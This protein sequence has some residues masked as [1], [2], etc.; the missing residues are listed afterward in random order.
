MASVHQVSAE[1]MPQPFV[2]EVAQ[3]LGRGLKWPR[4][5]YPGL[6]P[7][8]VIEGADE[9]LIFYGREEQ[10]DEILARLNRAHVVFVIGPSGCGKSSLIMAGVIPAL[11]AG[12]L[13]RAGHRWRCARMRPGR[14]P[15]ACLAEVLA[16]LLPDTHGS[17]DERRAAIE[18]LAR[19][20]DSALWL[21]A[22]T[23]A[24]R[25]GRVLLILDQFEELFAPEIESG[26]EVTQL[27]N[28]LTRFFE[29]PHENLYLVLAMRTD[30]MGR[31]AS[32]PHLAEMLNR[33]QYLTPVLTPA[34][35]RVAITRPAEA[36]GGRVEPALV[37][38]LLADMA[39]LHEDHAD[40]LPLLQ[41]ALFWLWEQAWRRSG[42]SEPPR[43]GQGPTS[44]M[45]ELA[46]EDYRSQ[47]RL[48]GILNAHA[49]AV[50][51]KAT[52]DGQ[53]GRRRSLC[54]CVFKRL[55]ERDL[56]YRYRR[57]PATLKEIADATDAKP[58]A[59][60]AVVRPFVAPN[61]SLLELRKPRR[62]GEDFVD[63]SHESL[64]RQWERLRRWADAEADDVHYFR[65]L[66]GSA[67]RWAKAGR[68][69]KDL[70][71]G[72]ELE[73]VQ[74][75]W[76]QRKP[77]QSWARR[78]YLDHRCVTNLAT[79][80]PLVEEYRRACEAQDEKIKQERERARRRE[81]E[82]LKRE[83]K[84]S[85]R[86]MWVSWAAG[87]LCTAVVAAAWW[88]NA[89]RAREEKAR[90]AAALGQFVLP[91]DG[92]NT[93]L[94]IAL[95]ALG[96]D[97]LPV[98][99]ETQQ[100]VR[101]ALADHRLERVILGH[102]GQVTSVDYRPDDG[103]LL[104]ADSAGTLRVWD[105]AENA[106][107]AQTKLSDLSFFCCRWSPLGDKV[108][109]STRE[110]SRAS[111]FEFNRDAPDRLRKLFDLKG[112]A[113]PGV[114]SHDERYIVTGSFLSPV[115][116]WDATNG[117][118]IRQIGGPAP[119]IAID[120]SSPRVAVATRDGVILLYDLDDVRAGVFEPRLK[121]DAAVP[122]GNFFSLAFHPTKPD[123]LAAGSSMG[124][125]LLW[126]LGDKTEAKPR[127]F[128][129]H[130]GAIFSLAFSPDGGTIATASE[131]RT[132]RLSD[133]ATGKVEVLRG[134]KNGIWS[135]AF[136]PS[137]HQI[138]SGSSDSTARIWNI[139][140]AD[141][142]PPKGELRREELIALAIPHVPETLDQDGKVAPMTLDPQ[143]RCVLGLSEARDCSA[144]GGE[145]TAAL[146][147]ESRLGRC[148]S[149]RGRGDSGRTRW[150]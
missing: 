119:A 21:L 25:P 79:V 39:A 10:K 68:L 132:L 101:K 85:L 60:L 64:I 49:E 47:G 71:T 145:E 117:S 147:R 96:S 69:G 126:D 144:E 111:L 4:Q 105:V 34:Q 19:E 74:K 15:L 77:T 57:A 37:E 55:S 127:P 75:W 84:A 95:E 52:A 86:L 3:S 8:K 51:A 121:L 89:D 1:T 73:V 125:G 100:L 133:L 40:Q 98:V 42:L 131:D 103:L 54:E 134:H 33:T 66:V 118:L 102:E 91:R 5:P 128:V 24:A 26:E 142:D 137:G 46:L 6:R 114:F 90:I 81:V 108:L 149:N 97:G 150:S 32:Y 41:H 58:E 106:L 109:A 122:G 59:V 124:S 61:A 140:P 141:S 76:S 123:V 115:R 138:A 45:P 110:A 56:E 11:N 87:A 99:D 63:V 23:M 88:I 92:A 62:K 35:L 107:V 13:T 30:Y 43:P 113:G 27:V 72:G 14:R 94:L 28:L 17:L 9:S 22:D 53:D 78:Y 93:A 65:T 82:A 20:E 135:L 139:E 36:Y 67:Q 80:L 31:C 48:R 18:Q 120:R 12:L 130:D 146:I 143:L 50:F 70:R 16:P 136:T 112:E 7:F 148:A 129:R 104:T 44:G 38:T 29:R 2:E 83:K 116:L